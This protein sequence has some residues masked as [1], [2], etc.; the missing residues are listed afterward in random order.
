MKVILFVTQATLAC[1][2]SQVAIE[3]QHYLK[4]LRTL[5]MCDEWIQ[6]AF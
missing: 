3:W 1:F 4:R 2:I 5:D 6:F